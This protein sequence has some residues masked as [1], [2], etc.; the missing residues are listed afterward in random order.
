MI[1][2]TWKFQGPEKHLKLSGN[3]IV[4]KQESN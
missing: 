3:V 4:N 1:Q 2:K